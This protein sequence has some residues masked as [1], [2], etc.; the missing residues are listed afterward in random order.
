MLSIETDM[1]T[2]LKEFRINLAIILRGKDFG[3]SVSTVH[4]L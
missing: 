1:V 3:Y 2:S 4:L